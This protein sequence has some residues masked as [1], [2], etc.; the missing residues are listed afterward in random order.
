MI[1]TS[2]PW[3]SRSAAKPLASLSS[4]RAMAETLCSPASRRARASSGTEK[5]GRPSRFEKLSAGVPRAPK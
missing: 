2:A 1:P 5:P 3:R 4:G